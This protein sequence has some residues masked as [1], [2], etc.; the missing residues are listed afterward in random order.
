MSD[1]TLGDCFRS[2]GAALKSMFRGS[3]YS[4]GDAVRS[5]GAA[6]REMWHR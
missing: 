1:Y 3:G 4:V 6:W 5:N 2:N